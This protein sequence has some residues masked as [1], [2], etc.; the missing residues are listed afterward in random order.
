MDPK[1]L[2]WQS[3]FT[4]YSCIP[5]KG[6][7]PNCSTSQESIGHL[8]SRWQMS[9][10]S[11]TQCLH[12]RQVSFDQL[13]AASQLRSVSWLL[14]ETTAPPMEIWDQP[15][16]SFV[17]CSLWTAPWLPLLPPS[18]SQKEILLSVVLIFTVWKVEEGSRNH[19]CSCL[20]CLK[21]TYV[22]QRMGDGVILYTRKSASQAKQYVHCSWNLISV[23][24]DN[25]FLPWCLEYWGSMKVFL[26]LR[27]SIFAP[28][29]SN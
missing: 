14:R 15:P 2:P 26:W 10:L 12:V 23:A 9:P 28:M 24:A 19:T 8:L 29:S 25:F 17:P 22:G 18:S 7:L 11:V 20:F 3:K 5:S 4:G 1:E 21:K 16:S 6:S 27:W 13:P